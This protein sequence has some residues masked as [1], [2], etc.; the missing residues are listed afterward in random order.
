[1]QRHRGF[2]GA[3]R[4]TG[5]GK[6]SISRRRCLSNINVPPDEGHEDSH[7]RA[8]RAAKLVQNLHGGEMGLVGR[9]VRRRARD[10]IF[11]RGGRG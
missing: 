10:G 6:I 11:G 5:Y 4:D 9:T 8:R 1:M 2:L 7:D 3:V